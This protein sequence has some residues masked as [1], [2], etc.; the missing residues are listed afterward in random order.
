MDEK[1]RRDVLKMGGTALAGAL[2]GCSNISTRTGD[3]EEQTATPAPTDTS[4][5]T[6]EPV[7]FQEMVE[8]RNLEPVPIETEETRETPAGG[9]LEV[10][11]AENLE[12]IQT[13]LNGR[14][15]QNNIQNSKLAWQTG[16]NQIKPGEN[17]LQIKATDKNGNQYTEE[18]SFE[19]PSIP[20]LLSIEDPTGQGLET[21]YQTERS[22]DTHTVQTSEEQFQQFYNDDFRTARLNLEGFG[23]TPEA[24]KQHAQEQL[25]KDKGNHEVQDFIYG[26]GAGT[27]IETPDT[28]W[29]SGGMV[30]TLNGLAREYSDK[31]LDG[32][33]HF[34]WTNATYGDPD[35]DGDTII[36]HEQG[37]VIDQETGE[38]EWF[39]KPL[40]N[41]YG[42][43]QDEVRKPGETEYFNPENNEMA[44]A[45]DFSKLMEAG[46]IRPERLNGDLLQCNLGF[47]DANQNSIERT[48][49]TTQPYM[50]R[51]LAQEYD[52]NLYNWDS[53]FTQ[54]L[55]KDGKKVIDLFNNYRGQN[56][57][58]MNQKDNER[59]FV[60]NLPD[61]LKER[62]SKFQYDNFLKDIAPELEMDPNQIRNSL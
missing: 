19:T 37:Y 27:T 38:L 60:V 49:E 15:T 23:T 3:T 17:K 35:I 2:A 53:G 55:E 8:T 33:Y 43:P 22:W 50:G 9:V 45:F 48:D 40:F 25:N 18:F 6:A 54:T 61:N 62:T 56:N 11:N 52:T 1:K 12:E 41:Q 20:F 58:V 10:N 44:L 28:N 39:F 13:L 31:L 24:V 5:A 7:G 47:I 36:T 57:L 26:L 42:S 30:Q 29:G 4:T 32:D 34:F 51:E 14:E 16:Q 46:K 21:G 59:Y